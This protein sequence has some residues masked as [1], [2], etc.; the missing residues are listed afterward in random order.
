MLLATLWALCTPNPLELVDRESVE[1]CDRTQKWY[2]FVMIDFFS[3]EL[4]GRQSIMSQQIKPKLQNIIQKVLCSLNEMSYDVWDQRSLHIYV[5]IA[6]ETIFILEIYRH[7]RHFENG[8]HKITISLE[9][10]QSQTILQCSLPER[11]I[12][13]E[14]HAITPASWNWLQFKIYLLDRGSVRRIHRP[15]KMAAGHLPTSSHNFAW[16]GVI[17]HDRTT[18]LTLQAKYDHTMS[19]GYP[20]VAY[21]LEISFWIRNLFTH[22]QTLPGRF[23]IDSESIDHRVKFVY[24]D[25]ITGS[26]ESRDH[27]YDARLI[28]W[29]LKSLLPR[30]IH[31]S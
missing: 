9:N 6:R 18:K 13:N 15:V 25:V 7:N 31:F 21:P 20:K 28:H 30:T 26:R 5:P 22:G 8:Y 3:P 24:G 19:A 17:N 29:I 4:N 27:H 10:R 2:F 16:R 11:E 12:N 1:I 23:A 14:V